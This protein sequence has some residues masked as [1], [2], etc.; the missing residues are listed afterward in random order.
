MKSQ[1]RAFT[2]IELIV[3]IGVIAML[4]AILFPVFAQAR[5]AARKTSCQSNLRQLGMAFHLYAQEYDE[6]LPPYLTPVKY[7]GVW[8]RYPPLLQPYIQSRHLLACPDDVGDG[9]YKS[10]F[11]ASDLGLTSY[12]FNATRGTYWDRGKTIGLTD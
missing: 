1:R 8:W 6:R 5:R 7:Q 2:L 9:T 3:V 11:Q 10:Y 4:A 12:F